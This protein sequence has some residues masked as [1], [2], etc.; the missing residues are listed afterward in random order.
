MGSTNLSGLSSVLL[1][2]PALRLSLVT[3]GEKSTVDANI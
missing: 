3:W 1:A 2:R